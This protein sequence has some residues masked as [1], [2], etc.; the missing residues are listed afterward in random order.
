MK[1][2][3][4]ICVIILLPI[5]AFA[6]MSTIPDSEMATVTGQMGVSIAIIDQ[7][8]DISIASVTWG[9]VN[10]SSR[11][12]AGQATNISPGYINLND[13]SINKNTT[14]DNDVSTP[15]GRFADPYKIDVVSFGAVSATQPFVA[16]ANKTAVIISLPD[17]LQT[18]DSITIGSITL[19]SS[20]ATVTTTAGGSARGTAAFY[21]ALNPVDSMTIR[22]RSQQ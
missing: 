22:T 3:L 13:I 9:D 4:V 18:I 15:V 10:T 19:D 12:I 14:T 16:L 6:G 2:L 7:Q 11:Y 17:E 21:A 8:Q 5:S 20:V 1:K